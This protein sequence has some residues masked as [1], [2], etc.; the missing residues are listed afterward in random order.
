MASFI[1]KI[2][3]RLVLLATNPVSHWLFDPLEKFLNPYSSSTA[4]ALAGY[5]VVIITGGNDLLTLQNSLTSI[6]QELSGS[7]AEIIIV[8]PA[9]LQLTKEFSLP[10]KIVPYSDLSFL[11]PLITRKKNIGVSLAQY[12]KVVLTHDYILFESGWKAA[13]DKFGTDFD[14][15]M[16]QIKDQDGSRFR[17][18]LVLDYPGIGAGFLPYHTEATPYQYI[19]GTYFVVKR[20]FYLANPL[21]ESLRWGEGEDIEWSKRVR[22]K[23]IFKFNPYSVVRC[24]KL[25][26]SILIWEQNNL[27]L[28]KIFAK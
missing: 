13:W 22:L 9:K 14:V 28:E 5:S 3:R 7:R 8:G 26:G 12:D 6:D 1:A 19:S 18:W 11:S 4:P 2:K 27:A 16:N 20:D 17:D 23:T 15:A 10:I 24:S 21:D 25:K